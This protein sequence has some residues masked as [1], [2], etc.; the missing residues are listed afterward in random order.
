MTSEPLALEMGGPAER[1]QAF[2]RRLAARLEPSYRLATLLL[3]DRR[4]AE[5]ATHDAVV[6]ALAASTSLRD[7]AAFDAWF[8]R[9]LVNACRDAGRRRGTERTRSIDD[10]TPVPS[11]PDPNADH[12]ERDA[13]RRA[14]AD[15]SLEHREVI[16]LRFYADLAIDDIARSLGIRAGTAKSRLHRALGVLRAEYEAASRPTKEALR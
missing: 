7:P 1:A 11:L 14:L 6:K 16:V 9:I 3:G 8:R 12:A 15:L 4:L 10:D 13:L 5:E 2:R